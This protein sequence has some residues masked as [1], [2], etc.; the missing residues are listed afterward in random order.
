MQRAPVDGAG[1]TARRCY[2]CLFKTHCSPFVPPLKEEIGEIGHTIPKEMVQNRT[3]VQNVDI[4][5]PLFQEE[6]GEVVQF[7]HHVNVVHVPM[8]VSESDSGMRSTRS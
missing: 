1:G 5:L 7:V 2:L 8:G 4:P 3:T 6:I